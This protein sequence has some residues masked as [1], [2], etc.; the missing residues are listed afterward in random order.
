MRWY[1]GGT[2]TEWITYFDIDTDN[3]ATKLSILIGVAGAL[4][5]LHSVCHIT[6]EDLKTDNIMVMHSSS[7]KTSLFMIAQ[8]DDNNHPV[9]IN[10]GLS[11]TERK[12]PHCAVVYTPIRMSWHWTFHRS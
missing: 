6:H 11:F 7:T 3:D 2:L 10:F 1:N 4:D 5:H 9:I 8:I 12:A